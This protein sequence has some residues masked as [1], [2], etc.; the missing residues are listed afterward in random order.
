MLMSPE[1]LHALRLERADIMCVCVC[2]CACVCVCVCTNTPI[3]TYTYEV[4][5]CHRT[6]SWGTFVDDQNLT[7]GHAMSG[8]RLEGVG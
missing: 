4:K 3:Y 6:G 1:L 2:V 8:R 7:R 5:F